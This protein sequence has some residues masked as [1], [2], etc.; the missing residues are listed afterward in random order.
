MKFVIV[1]FL[2]S[3]LP[4]S[5][6]KEGQIDP[7]DLKLQYAF[8]VVRHG[9]RAP[10]APDPL[11]TVSKTQMLTPQGMRQ[12]FLLG[13]FNYYQYSKDFGE[14][15]LNTENGIKMQSTNVLRTIQSGY[16]ELM[17]MIY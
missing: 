9:A 8:E 17:G 15:I 7:S 1:P 6:I 3:L 14:D 10:F 11:F 16:S 12:R 13:R 4:G 2:L 5:Y